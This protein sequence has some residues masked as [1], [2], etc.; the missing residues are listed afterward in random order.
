MGPWYTGSMNPNALLHSVTASASL[1]TVPDVQSHRAVVVHRLSGNDPVFFR[2]G[3][4][5]ATP[6][7]AVVGGPDQW[8]LHSGL[9]VQ[10]IPMSGSKL[11][12][13]SLKISAISATPATIYIQVM[14]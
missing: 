14:D 10:E 5:G 7:D 11:E 1:A 12:G 4:L 13:N 6:A 3:V 8:V 9:T 2:V